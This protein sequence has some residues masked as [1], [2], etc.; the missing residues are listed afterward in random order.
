MGAFSKLPNKNK[1]L[2]KKLLNHNPGLLKSIETK[3]DLKK[4]VSN[5]KYIKERRAS[6]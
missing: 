4:N 6:N 5:Q 2:Q 1:K 3:I